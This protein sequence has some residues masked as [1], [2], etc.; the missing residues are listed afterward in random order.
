MSNWNKAQDWEAGWWNTCQNTYG[1]EEKQFS[2]AERMGLQKLTDSQGPHFVIGNKSILDVG[3][4][5]VS[6]LLK[7][8]TG[9]RR[10]VADPCDYPSWIGERYKSAGIEYYKTKGEE[11]SFDEVFDE[12]W[13]Y[14][15]LQ[16]VDDPKKVIANCL[17][18]GK[19]VRV[20]EWLNIGTGAGH[21]HNLIEKDLNRWLGG[22]GKVE[23]AYRG[24]EYFGIF[25]GNSDA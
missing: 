12:V 4:G 6:L 13:L 16:H 17:Q 25:V 23:K 21:P 11:L 1:E 20:F 18:Y 10:V 9:G 8:R 22:E 5:P 14:N 3:G 19:I 2:Y 15:V 24:K 7:C